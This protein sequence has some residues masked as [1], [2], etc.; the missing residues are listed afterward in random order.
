MLK[1]GNLSTS[2]NRLSEFEEQKSQIIYCKL[3]NKFVL[4]AEKSPSNQKN[5]II[6]SPSGDIY[7]GKFRSLKK[8]TYQGLGCL[9]SSYSN[10][11]Y[12]GQF[13][14]SKFDGFGQLEKS[15]YVYIG[16]FKM[17]KKNGYGFRKSNVDDEILIGFFE[18][19]DING[20]C[21]VYKRR[22]DLY[23]GEMVE[24]KMSGVGMLKKPE[25][26]YFGEFQNDVINGLGIKVQGAYNLQK[27]LKDISFDYF[28]GKWKRGIPQ[29]YG[30]KKEKGEVYEGEFLNGVKHGYGRFENTDAL[31][32]F[33][34]VGEFRDDFMNGFGKIEAGDYT[35]IGNW[36]KG[37]RNGLGFYKSS[38]GSY[39]G[40]W[41]TDKRS[42]L[43]IADQKK[44]KIK[45]EWKDDNPVG[46]FLVSSLNSSNDKTAFIK[47]GKIEVMYADCET[48]KIRLNTLDPHEF[49]IVADSKLKVI[50]GFIKDQRE[51]LMSFYDKMQDKFLRE[52]KRLRDKINSTLTHTSKLKEII[53]LNYLDLLKRIKDCGYDIHSIIKNTEKDAVI[54]QQEAAILGKNKILRSHD[55]IN[56]IL[57]RTDISFT[58]VRP[59]LHSFLKM[60]PGNVEEDKIF[61]IG[62]NRV[63]LVRD[64]LESPKKEI[65]P[66]KKLKDKLKEK[67][68]G[69]QNLSF[70]T[71]KV[72]IE[73]K[74][75]KKTIERQKRNTEKF[76]KLRELEEKLNI[77][78]KKFKNER[79]SM[80]DDKQNI[81]KLYQEHSN[82]KQ[83]HERHL[84]KFDRM[85]LEIKKTESNLKRLYPDLHKGVEENKLKEENLKEIQ[86]KARDIKRDMAIQKSLTVEKKSRAKKMKKE[87]EKEEEENEIL[88]KK[89]RIELTERELQFE[90]ECRRA[91][92]MGKLKDPL[93]HEIDELE[94]KLKKEARGR[95]KLSDVFEQ[96]QRALNRYIEAY[97]RKEE[98]K[99]TIRDKKGEQRKIEM[100]MDEA[101]Q[102]KLAEK[103]GIKD[104]VDEKYQGIQDTLKKYDVERVRMKKGKEKFDLGDQVLKDKSKNLEQIKRNIQKIHKIRLE[105]LKKKR[106]IK[107][108]K[109]LKQ[110]RIGLAEEKYEHEKKELVEEIKNKNEELEKKKQRFEEEKM[111]IKESHKQEQKKLE[112]K[113]EGL[114]EIKSEIADI[115]NDNKQHHIINDESKHFFEDMEEDN[116]KPVKMNLFYNFF[117]KKLAMKKTARN[118]K[119]N[120]MK[121]RPKSK[122]TVINFELKNLDKALEKAKGGQISDF[123]YES[124]PR[125][126]LEEFITG[127]HKNKKFTV[128][129]LDDLGLDKDISEEEDLAPNPQTK[130]DPTGR[131]VR[132]SSFHQMSKV[133][134]EDGKNLKNYR[135]GLNSLTRD[136]VIQTRKKTKEKCIA[137][138]RDLKRHL[139]QI[140]ELKKY[141]TDKENYTKNEDNEEEY[142]ENGEV[143]TFIEKIRR[144]NLAFFR[145][146]AEPELDVKL[147]KSNKIDID[148]KGEFMY[149]GCEDAFR[150]FDITGNRPYLMREIMEFKKC[151]EV[152]ALENR[153][154]LVV[155]G[156]TNNLVVLD[157]E[158]NQIKLVEGEPDIERNFNF[159]SKFL[160]YFLIF[161]FDQRPQVQVLSLYWG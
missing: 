39:F 149:V 58:P 116:P 50:I 16:E 49:E 21:E 78:E 139:E 11:N 100:N 124:K 97:K 157:E 112:K 22:F 132:S 42:G 79:K 8:P 96:K 75:Y 44:Y 127:K 89:K 93:H 74:N 3:K 115:E 10:F 28:F 7:H 18:N 53:N 150:V 15:R 156:D 125:T 87:I 64:K 91:I 108:L 54:L 63:K 17:G 131:K 152:K 13:L 19:G 34:Y 68:T 142:D 130:T 9:E 151:K 128:V 29:N 140:L 99:K 25:S 51:A 77:E 113:Q 155:Y 72:K 137:E 146:K 1:Q 67:Q 24:S 92:M 62:P 86:K 141:I 37:H 143:L 80:T 134:K 158:Y 56:D 35:Y 84:A 85:E 95:S 106:N 61:H 147:E 161:R 43:G 107:K 32:G 126:K 46:P 117:I 4:L 30:I 83:E 76:K 12:S 109:I 57:D 129:D 14:N 69:Y 66:L 23:K 98:L 81:I 101:L 111:K 122:G 154:V 60:L 2:S 136:A 65:D 104:K 90:S 153:R 47:D 144:K 159:F 6:L 105:L 135:S 110:Q 114:K 55:D 82:L 45:A 148:M 94:Q 38:S 102:A 145:T 41:A 59:E 103:D 123:D 133:L 160:E 26:C 138:I 118:E 71:K 5:G 52:E 121:N 119:L 88:V 48:L 70:D 36:K 40:L 31:N 120:G 73:V 20:W 33:I 27:R